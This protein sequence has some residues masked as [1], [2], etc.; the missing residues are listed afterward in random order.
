MVGTAYKQ[1]SREKAIKLG[2]DFF[3]PKMRGMVEE[4]ETLLRSRQGAGNDPGGEPS[5]INNCIYVYCWRGGMRSGAVSWLLGLY[6]FRVY[7][8]AGGYKAFRHL[9]LKTFAEPFELRILGGYT[10]SGKTALLEE[11]EKK[12]ETVI[13]LEKIACHKGSAFGNIKM[14]AQPSQEMF[15]NILAEELRKKASPGP[16]RDTSGS[17]SAGRR[18]PLWLED[19]SQRIGNLNIPLAF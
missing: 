7:T 14:P 18:L 11:L 3:G 6:G 2:L 17:P 16:D 15:E 8:L 9:A 1:E 10:G 5:S 19:E 13:D 4:V 12:G